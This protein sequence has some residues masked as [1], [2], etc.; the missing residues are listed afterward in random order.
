[1]LLVD[2]CDSVL[3]AV[4]AYKCTESH[5]WNEAITHNYFRDCVVN[6]VYVSE[7]DKLIKAHSKLIGK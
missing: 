3:H 2:L 1:M 6:L 4:P 7:A 5:K